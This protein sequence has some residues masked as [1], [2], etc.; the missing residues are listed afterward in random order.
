MKIVVSLVLTAALALPSLGMAGTGGTEFNSAYTTMTDWLSG[1][2]GRLIAAGLLIVGL[3]RGI[4]MQS[5]MAAVPAIAVGL[6][7][8][9][10]PTVINAIV[11]ATL[12][13]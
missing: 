6:V 11:T 10:A 5:V 3:A 1:D 13:I 8:S 9:V 4:V 12:P 2:L 7:V